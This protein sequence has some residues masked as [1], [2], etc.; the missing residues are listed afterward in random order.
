M[1][2]C[3]ARFLSSRVVEAKIVGRPPL[4]TANE[5]GVGR[6]AFVSVVRLARLRKTRHRLTHGPRHDAGDGK[7][8]ARGCFKIRYPKRYPGII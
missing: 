7:N 5:A 3:L 4:T 1:S 2:C 8:A 6:D